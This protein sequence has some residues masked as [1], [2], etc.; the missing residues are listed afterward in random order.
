MIPAGRRGCARWFLLRSRAKRCAFVF[1][2]AALTPAAARPAAY[3]VSPHGNDSGPGTETQPWRTIDRVNRARLAAGDR[4]LFEGGQ[5]FAGDLVLDERVSTDPARPLV[6]ASYGE[7]RALIQAGGGTAILVRNIGGVVIRNLVLAGESAA[8]NRGFG[9]E[10]VNERGAARLAAVWLDNLD[11]SGF[12]W[13]GIYVGGVPGLPGAREPARGRFGY[14]DVRIERSVAHANMYYGIWVSGPWAGWKGRP[15]GYANEDVTISDCVARDNPGDPAYTKNHSGNGILLDD[16][17][18]GLI[19]HCTAWHNGAENGST[20]GGPVGIWADESNRVTIQYC[21][22]YDN[23]TGGAADGGGFDLDGGVTDSVEQYNYSHGNDGAGFLVWSY[24]GAVHPL[25][26]NVIRYN[27]SANDGRRHR[28]GGVHIGTSGGGVQNIDV[29]N[30]TVYM[31]AAAAESAP[32]RTRSA[33]SA[34][35]RAV[36][37][38]GSEP[39][40]AIRFFNNLL[41]A[42]PGVPLVEVEPRQEKITFQGNAYWPRG[43]SFMVLDRGARYTTLESW[44]AATGEERGEG[45]ATG[46]AA[47]PKLT[48]VN[49]G[50]S[51]GGRRALATLSAFRLL[52]GSPLIDAGLDLAARFGLDVGAQDFW[53]TPLPQGRGFDVGA[54]EAPVRPN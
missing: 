49:A 39:L 6:I 42:G 18:G 24:G 31:P 13:A 29:Y 16:T 32:P 23:R 54:C 41:M 40:T 46:I 30:N 22:S 19:D 4:V 43:G 2:L 12:H 10:V 5:S 44:R 37:V 25:A 47:D 28:Y 45:G 9:V 38:G 53:G 26:H 17:D 52:P 48:A 27:I 14:R 34:G 33:A 36:W 1:L 11:V 15:A 50:E 20:E 21:E 3:Y 8:A 35:P 51:M 7:G